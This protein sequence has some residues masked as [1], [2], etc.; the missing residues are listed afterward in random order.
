MPCGSPLAELDLPVWATLQK[1][2]WILQ[3]WLNVCLSPFTIQEVTLWKSEPASWKRWKEKPFQATTNAAVLV[4]AIMQQEHLQQSKS[5]LSLNSTVQAVFENRG[6]R[7]K[8][9][10]QLWPEDS[11]QAHNVQKTRTDADV[12]MPKAAER[13]AAEPNVGQNRWSR[14]T[15]RTIR[16]CSWY[17]PLGLAGGRYLP[18]TG[19]PGSLIQRS[20]GSVVSVRRR[21]SQSAAVLM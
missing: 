1:G 3:P 15:A 21:D 20:W 14:D 5:W 17:I 11:P 19:T 2:R 4:R 7:S 18:S 12:P 10:H 13:T 9:S 6:P 16:S 8:L